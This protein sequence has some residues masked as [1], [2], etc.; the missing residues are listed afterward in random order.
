[1]TSLKLIFNKEE[2]ERINALK[3]EYGLKTTTELIR[4]ILALQYKE[5]SKGR[6]VNTEEDTK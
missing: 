2:D 4:L 6:K 5:M 1:M 3:Q